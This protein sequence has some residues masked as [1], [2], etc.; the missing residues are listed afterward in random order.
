MA[1]LTVLL[2]GL[3]IYLRNNVTNLIPQA[4]IQGKG[5]HPSRTLLTLSGGGGSLY[6][7]MD[8]P[9]WNILKNKDFRS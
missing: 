9:E 2:W 1:S 8:L 4:V 5:P 6:N 3:L 7:L